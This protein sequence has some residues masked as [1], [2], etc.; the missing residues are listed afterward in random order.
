MRV[1]REIQKEELRNFLYRDLNIDDKNLY[2][3]ANK[4]N[5]IGIFQLTGG[6][7]R[8]L[9]A[10][11]KPTN[12]DEL[13]AVNAMARPGTIEF[14]PTYI[15]NTT[16]KYNEKINEIIKDTR[17]VILFQEQV[18][19]IFSKIGGFSLQEADKVRG[20]MKKLSKI[21]KGEDDVKAWN[22][23]VNKFTKNA[24]ESGL[25]EDEAKKITEDILSFSDYSFNR[26]HAASYTYIAVM[27]LYLSYYFKKYFFSSVLQYEIEK[28]NN[29]LDIMQS[30]KED[31][32]V[33]LLPDINKSDEKVK[34]LDNDKL[35]LGLSNIKGVGEKAIEKIIEAKPYDSLIDFIIK[36]RSRQV[37]SAVIVKLI[38]SGAFD[39]FINGER[40]R[41]VNVFNQFWKDKKAIKIEEKLKKIWADIETKSKTIPFTNT[42]INDLRGYE[43]ECFGFNFFTSLFTKDKIDAFKALRDKNLI[44]MNFNEVTNVSRKVPVI[45][46]SVRILKDKNDNSMA[47]I[48]IEDITG[49]SVSVPVFA[50]YWQHVSD[51][52][53]QD[54]LFLINLYKDDRDSFLFGQKAFV[55]NKAQVER[56][57]KEL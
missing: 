30:I 52:F 11:I 1:I 3:E 38:K 39:S 17:N 5:S 31:G 47:F 57:I 55:T 44:V 16:G 23:V 45:L 25:T 20:I 36:T 2:K 14:A 4:R 33:I 19:E 54:K 15:E 46:N 6:A 24:T 56:M 10:Q 9:M 50:S 40:K 32:F 18:M 28:D 26:A 37:T 41:Y 7:A 35:L 29:T 12:F 43:I 51:S 42:T 34:P 8:G 13:N 22:K 48:T 21:E 53:I 49:K 27:T